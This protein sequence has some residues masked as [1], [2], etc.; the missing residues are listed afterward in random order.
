[1]QEA[2][3]FDLSE[4]DQA[5]LEMMAQRSFTGTPDKVMQ[6]LDDMART[7]DL[8]EVFLLTLIPDLEARKTS[9]K[10]LAEQAGMAASATAAA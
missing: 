6:Q 1:L 8:A 3:D 2:Q 7:Y 9:Y 5:Y 10:L 4:T